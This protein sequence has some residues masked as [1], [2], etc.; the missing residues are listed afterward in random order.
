MLLVS[1]SEHIP[2]GVNKAPAQPSKIALLMKNPKLVERF[3]HIMNQT[4]V[5]RHL[6]QYSSTLFEESINS[7]IRISFSIFLSIIIMDG[8]L[9][10]F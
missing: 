8:E 9:C 5:F 6:S 7:A 3:P 1:H 4:V 2:Y 10:L